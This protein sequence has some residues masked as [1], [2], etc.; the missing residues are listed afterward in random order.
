MPAVSRKPDDILSISASSEALFRYQVVSK[1]LARELGG[2]A[3][4]H[5]A[6]AVAASAHVTVNG[7]ARSVSLRTLYRWLA[8][9]QKQ[10][11][12][13]LEPAQQPRV[14]ASAILS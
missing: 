4:A 6:R 8:A 11:F 9:Y 12:A 3:R 1:V 13:G 14:E 7:S 2:E 10:G 5:A